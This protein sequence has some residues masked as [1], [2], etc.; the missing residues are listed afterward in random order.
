LFDEATVDERVVGRPAVCPT[1]ESEESRT[2]RE[3]REL[4]KSQVTH[5]R[6]G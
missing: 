4:E 1:R 6:N 3:Q 5:R 2:E